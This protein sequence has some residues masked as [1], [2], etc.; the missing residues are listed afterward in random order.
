MREKDN[1]KILIVLSFANK[2]IKY[3]LPIQFE[4]GELLIGNYS[5]D[6]NELNHTLYLQ[7]NKGGVF[8]WLT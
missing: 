4:N 1:K 5:L 7:P 2:R 3:N 6:S 8:D